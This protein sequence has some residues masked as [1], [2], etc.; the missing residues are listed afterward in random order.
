MTIR[1][2]QPPDREAVRR[3]C[4]ITAYGGEARRLPDP[5]LFADLMTRYFTDLT[6][7]EPG[8]LWVAVRDGRVEGYLA[9][10][11]DPGR[12]RRGMA[13]RVV[14]LA[15][16]RSLARGRWLRPPFLRLVALLPRFLAAGGL[17]RG[18]DLSAYPVHLHVNLLPSAQGR[19][20]G[21]RLLER[22]LAEASRRGL[23]G[24]HATVLE[25]NVAGRRF[26]EQRGFRALARR[27]AFCLP[28]AGG[29]LEWKVVYGR[30]L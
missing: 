1:P 2:Y 21:T 9:G 18:P 14:P 10:S 26:F 19:A 27:P 8:A 25:S 5:E 23:A 7:L 16:A 24:A 15:V 13:L 11:L 12:W 20:V 3:I 22:C 4:R 6:D 28:P 29:R 17:G 30:R